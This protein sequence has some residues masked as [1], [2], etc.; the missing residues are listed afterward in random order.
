L[1]TPTRRCGGGR[2]LEAHWELFTDYRTHVAR[3]GEIAHFHRT[4]QPPTLIAWG[5]HDPYYDLDEVIAYHRELPAVES[6]L[7]D[8][9]HFLLETH[10][11][12]FLSVIRPVVARL[13]E[14]S[15][16]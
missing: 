8:A 5:V 13:V 14:Q 12:E 9:G 2:T 4:E 15:I 1:V 10:S 7:L 16:S 11:R 6:H 3:F